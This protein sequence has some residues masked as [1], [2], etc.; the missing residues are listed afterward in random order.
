MFSPCWPAPRG[1]FPGLPSHNNR[2]GCSYQRNQQE[3]PGRGGAA[4]NRP[5]PGQARA[6]TP[7]N[8]AS[9]SAFVA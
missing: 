7:R 3:N 8:L 4:E 5:L 9:C 2:D 1:P 6:T